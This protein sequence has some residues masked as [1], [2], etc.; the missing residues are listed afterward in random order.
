MAVLKEITKSLCPECLQEINA[1]IIE[2]NSQVFLEKACPQHGPFD[3]LIEKDAEFYKRIMNKDFRIEK[4][5]FR[6]LALPLTHKCNLNCNIC[7]LPDRDKRDFSVEEMKSAVQNFD[8]KLIKLTGGEPTLSDNLP[9]FIENVYE[10]KKDAGLVTNGV[11]LSDINYVRILKKSGLKNVALSF[12]GGFNDAIYEKISG[13]KMLNEKLRAL[14]NLK[15]E[16][17]GVTLSVTLIRGVNENE[18]GSIYR[19]YVNNAS[20]VKLLRIRSMSQVGKYIETKPFCLSEIIG[21]ISE[22]SGFSKDELIEPFFDFKRD[23]GSTC[24]F[25]LNLYDSFIYRIKK[26]KIDSSR[27]KYLM[28]ISEGLFLFGLGKTAKMIINKLKGKSRLFDQGIEIRTWPD[29]YS[30]DLGEIQWCYTASLTQNG[31]LLPFCY[32]IIMNEKTVLY[33]TCPIKSH[34]LHP[35]SPIIKL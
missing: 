33:N 7:Y 5:P 21:L 19:Y 15:S 11:R 30:I 35:I 13:R 12:H 24:R 16:G 10:N 2:K 34:N 17:I 14:R 25:S 32:S 23:P 20:F 28:Y 31:G 3:V 29:K 18:L 6:K 9:L 1:R 8:G 22:V 27:F 4:V 26:R